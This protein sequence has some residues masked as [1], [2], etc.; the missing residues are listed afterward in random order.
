MSE[1]VLAL[2][3]AGSIP[4][5]LFVG[6]LSPIGEVGLILMV[7][8]LVFA[9]R[10][11]SRFRWDLLRGAVAGALAGLVVLGP[12]FRLAMRVVAIT[13]AERVPEFTLGG[14]MFIVIGIGLVFGA[15]AG[16]Y[17]VS[18]GRL[19]RLRRMTI[20]VIATVGIMVFL[21]G[22]S[23]LRSELTDLGLGG[24]ANIPMF[25]LVVFTYCWALDAAA[26]RLERWAT[27]RR[28]MDAIGVS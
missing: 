25:G 20:S 12:G 18:A 8:V 4:L 16:A 6:S 23:E 26:R 22:D 14:T 13:D 19:L 27:D 11:V 2:I 9:S 10:Q 15:V 17:F 5:A 1:R 7:A 24:W 28:R 21:F 3:V